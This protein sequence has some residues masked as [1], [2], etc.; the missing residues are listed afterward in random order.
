[1]VNET[2]D[3]VGA[4]QIVAATALVIGVVALVILYLHSHRQR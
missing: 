1:L 2:G 4:M 3:I